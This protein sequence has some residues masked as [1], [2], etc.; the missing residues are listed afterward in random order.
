MSE[1]YVARGSS[2]DITFAPGEIPVRSVNRSVRA[3]TSLLWRKLES[4]SFEESR[5]QVYFVPQ[6]SHHWALMYSYIVTWL[7]L[8]V[9]ICSSQGL[10]HACLS[11][12]I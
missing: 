7:I 1:V 11:I 3:S 8:P 5:S 4:E 12:S 6:W 10:S 2:D 9:V